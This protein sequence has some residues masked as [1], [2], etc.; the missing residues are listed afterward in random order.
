MLVA[1]CGPTSYS[2]SMPPPPHTS[3]VPLRVTPAF[4][5]RRTTPLHPSMLSPVGGP[6]GRFFPLGEPGT[7]GKG[8]TPRAPTTPREK[9][10][11]T[12]GSM[13]RLR[14]P[15]SAGAVG[16]VGRPS[17]ALRR[18][19]EGAGAGAGVSTG[20]SAT[21]TTPLGG[22]AGAVYASFSKRMSETKMSVSHGP[23]SGSAGAGEPGARR[24]SST[25]R[26]ALISADS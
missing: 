3:T 25:L 9:E 19:A 2:S 4:S 8:A 1:S 16:S 5:P 10:N 26:R 6:H 17:S 20:G 18:R 24:S 23:D 7:G 22:T 14:A 21:R 12:P 13:S 11:A 15:P